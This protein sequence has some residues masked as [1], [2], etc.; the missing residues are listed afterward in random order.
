MMRNEAA[1]SN[2]FERPYLDEYYSVR[3][4]FQVAPPDDDTVPSRIVNSLI[5]VLNECQR[6]PRYLLVVNDRDLTASLNVFDR[7]VIKTI[8]EAVDWI[9]RQLLMQIRRKKLE[10]LNIKSGAVYGHDPTIIFIR[11]IRRVAFDH[12]HQHSKHG[13]LSEIYA[14]RPKFNDALN[15]ASA[16]INQRIMTINSCNTPSHFDKKGNLSDKGNPA[17]GL[18]WMT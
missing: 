7:E 16:R 9:T 10:L 2:H 11:M 1:A 17:F 12:N 8:R 18:R 14:L 4:Y 6:L 3:A 15:D 5:D 13:T